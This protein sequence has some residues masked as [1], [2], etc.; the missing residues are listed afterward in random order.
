M[1]KI[2]VGYHKPATLLKSEILAPMH[3][4]RAVMNE[5]SK[6]AG[7]SNND[8]E[9]LL[10]N[11]IGDDTRDNISYLNRYFCEMTGI[12]WAWKNYDKLENPEYFGFM[13]Y[14][15]L[16]DFIGI[17][18]SLKINKSIGLSN[19]DFLDDELIERLFN[20]NIIKSHINNNDFFIFKSR[21][22]NPYR[23]YKVTAEYLHI[24]DYDKC[25]E[26]IDNE[27]LEYKE[28]SKV[29]NSGKIKY[30]CN[31]FVLP[32]E[33]FFKYCEF[34]FGVL[35][36]LK[37]LINTDNYNNMEQRVFGYIA[38]WLTGIYF[39]YLKLHGHKIKELDVLYV[40]NTQTNMVLKK[41]FDSNYIPIIFSCDDVYI[42][43]LHVALKSL[44]DN[45]NVAKNYDVIILYN[46]IKENNIRDIVDNYSA[47]NFNI[48]FYN[49]KYL[50][51]KYKANYYSCRHFSSSMYYRIFIP[52]IMVDYDKVIYCD[53]DAIFLDDITKA[54][55]IDLD[56]NLIG[57]VKDF[58]VLK[59]KK[60]QKY[61]TNTLNI[62]NLDNYFNSGFII[63]DIKKCNEFDLINKCLELI[64]TKSNLKYP[65]QD[66]LNMIIKD[67]VKLIEPCWNVQNQIFMFD[68][69]NDFINYLSN[70]KFLHFTSSIKPWI[71]PTIPNADIWWSYA[72]N[73][74]FY[75]EILYECNINYNENNKIFNSDKILKNLL[76]YR[77]GRAKLWADCFYKKILLFF[78]YFYI[79]TTH[80]CRKVSNAIMIKLGFK[81]KQ[82]I[83]KKFIDFHKLKMIECSKEYK[84]GIGI[85]KNIRRKNEK[86]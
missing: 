19:I 33:Y 62:D 6:D 79:F 3:L 50:L 54:Y 67:K 32:K 13:H 24:E 68:Y 41:I 55:N 1:I 43:Y 61:I 42:P 4:G 29:Y 47:S 71:N 45:M 85:I 44:R 72:K 34:V 28:A 7:L 23:H 76:P 31:M 9:W 74:L 5:Q 10:S 38:E 35:F 81:K 36:K 75:E 52:E 22:G 78:I 17:S 37:D 27:F 39:T 16:F 84:I 15:R 70:P 69:K 26:I 59:F 64:K 63:F 80:F 46:D 82:P 65:D 73:T 58:S 14:R 56:D 8:K 51:Y 40:Q 18:K 60:M 2:L 86:I 30:F 83:L 20:K 49:V 21:K 66:I 25:L 48:R 12:Y 11:M 53:C 77:L 57:A